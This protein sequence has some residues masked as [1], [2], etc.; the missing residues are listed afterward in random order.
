[1][2]HFKQFTVAVSLSLA[3]TLCGAEY[4]IF[5]P[6][7]ELGTA[8]FI[9]NKFLRPDLN[10]KMVFEHPVI[11]SKDKVSGNASLR[12]PNRFA[13]RVALAGREVQLEKGKK[14][15][16]S[17]WMK[18]SVPQSVSVS[19][20]GTHPE[21]R[22]DSNSKRFNVGTEWKEYS[23]TFTPKK[24][25]RF[26]SPRLTFCEKLSDP[27]SELW[28]D[29]WTLRP[30][31]SDKKSEQVQIAAVPEKNYFIRKDNEILNVPVKVSVHNPGKSS[32]KVKA[33][34]VA[35][36]DFSGNWPES[37]I[38]GKSV[39]VS[40]PEM[41]LAAGE[42]KNITVKMPVSRFGSY[43]LTPKAANAS[44][45]G[46]PFAVIGKVT[47]VSKSIKPPFCMA[48]NGRDLYSRPPNYK[49]KTL[50]FQGME[51]SP[52]DY[53]KF[54][55]D[56]G[57]RL[58]RGFGYPD[59]GISWLT[60]EPEE[61]KFDF[62]N[63]DRFVNL[64]SKHG[65]QLLPV[66]G[67]Y[68]FS[69]S[70]NFKKKRELPV[71]LP[72]WLIPLCKKKLL[73]GKTTMKLNAQLTP[74]MELWGRLVGKIAERYKGRIGQYEIINEPHLMFRN[75][76]DYF[77][78]LK[79]GYEAIKKADPNATV[80]GFCATSD[81]GARMEAFYKPNFQAGG[82]NYADAV[83]F[84]PYQNPK[85]GSLQPADRM[86]KT[87]RDMIKEFSPKQYQLW[88]TE[89]YYLRGDVGNSWIKGYSGSA[90]LAQRTM[91]DLGEGVAQS[92]SIE[93][94][95]LQR[96]SGPHFISSDGFIADLSPNSH[97]VTLNAMARL[98]EGASPADKLRWKQDVICYVVRRA[99]GTLAAV[100][101]HYGTR[102]GLSVSLPK[103]DKRAELLDM[104]S[105]PMPWKKFALPSD[106]APCY[107]L[108]NGKD[109]NEFVKFL[110]GFAVESE[111]PLMVSPMIRLIPSDNGGWKAA[112]T[113]KNT[114][115]KP[116]SGRIGLAGDGISAKGAP[117]F[118]VKA[119][120]QKVVEIPVTVKSES[121][122]AEIRLLYNGQRV[123][124]PV[125]IPPKTSVYRLGNTWEKF[126]VKKGKIPPANA[127]WQ[128][129]EENGEL[130]LRVEVKDATPSGKSGTRKAWEQDCVEVFIDNAPGMIPL[131][132][133]ASYH[134]GCYRLFLLPYAEAGKQI[135]FMHT[136]GT[137]LNDKTV[138]MKTDI[139][140]D[141]YALTLRIRTSALNLAAPGRMGMEL[142]VNNAEF[143]KTGSSSSSWS[144]AK[145][146]F[147]N[148]MGFG[149]L[150]W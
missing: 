145:M 68:D 38:L 129:K 113:L 1:M 93:H 2:K 65:I 7:F 35:T 85:L 44:T 100:F 77:P 149:I 94:C 29:D 105:N 79:T 16:C 67:E 48:V 75:P 132:H 39:K 28:V 140:K 116:V 95:Q 84:H 138:T 147:N 127:K 80:V 71:G 9:C 146:P 46:K 40:V 23:F 45:F 144:G 114:S 102:N 87:I 74:P 50:A 22:W 61:G 133:S 90:D 47:P 30:A 18:S 89:L 121:G 33:E 99:D 37:T 3:A 120:E 86:V 6:G 106:N 14:Y 17:L 69:T 131:E 34:L 126:T 60:L 19:V 92:I 101:W 25:V 62:E 59:G 4:E 26:Y 5:N 104:M 134:K 31:D 141:G 142:T 107:I 20:I 52:D 57:I 135:Q 111:Q 51:C 109:K 98:F 21:L 36:E 124:V 41:T 53:M 13:E 55:A 115:S 150:T 110:N 96:T 97:A 42:T 137:G 27:V 32:K 136:K 76:A 91:L 83:S 128:M 54:L 143:Q 148:R 12:I 123:N 117:K 15:I 73:P 118:E 11:D 78:F 88:N 139:S 66:L 103:K 10:K 58:I 56:H 64:T 49:Y 8:G 82:L 70:N 63:L 125:T 24:T 122:K 72:E 108:W 81:L 119:D 43:L 130:V 112:V